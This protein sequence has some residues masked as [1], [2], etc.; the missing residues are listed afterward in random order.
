MEQLHKVGRSLRLSRK[1]RSLLKL[2]RLTGD[3]SPCLVVFLLLLFTLHLSPFTLRVLADAPRPQARVVSQTVGNDELLHAVADPGQIACLSHLSRDSSF[4]AIAREAAA[5]P[6][7][8]KN[9]T[10]ETILSHEP[11]LVIFNDYSRV[12]LVEQVRR[13][14]V[15]VIVISKYYTLEDAFDNLR[16]IARELGPRAEARAEAII[17]DGLRRVAALRETLKG[18]KPVRVI[19]PSTYGLIPGD[20]STFQDLCDYARAENLASTLGRLHGHQAPPSEKMLTWPIDKVVLIGAD[21]NAALAPY[22]KL[23]PYQYMSAIREGRVAL[24]EPWQISCVSHLRIGA[25]ERLARELH[26]AR[27]PL[28]NNGK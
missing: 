11:T 5:F 20:Q 1:Q 14:G 27:F 26:P 6:S 8:Q 18:A 28:M 16:M 25:Y 7:L 17:A 24:L 21:K 9:A 23:P 3:G 22:E 15:R 2:F 10:A 4:S 12:E 19:A 13:A